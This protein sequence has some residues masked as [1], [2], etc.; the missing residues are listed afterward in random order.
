MMPGFWVVL[1]PVTPFPAALCP[2]ELLTAECADL[3]A[4]L[5]EYYGGLIV[6]HRGTLSAA[7]GR[8]P[9]LVGLAS[10]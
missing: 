6:C 3:L 5:G 7:V 1:V 9:D 10:S 4:D 2:G 8:A